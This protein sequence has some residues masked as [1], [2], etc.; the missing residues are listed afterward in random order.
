MSISVLLTGTDGQSD[1]LY[2]LESLGDDFFMRRL[3]AAVSLTDVKQLNTIRFTSLGG[4][5]CANDIPSMLRFWMKEG[6]GPTALGL[7]VAAGEL[8]LHDL[9]GLCLT[10]HLCLTKHLYSWTCRL[11]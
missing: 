11:V 10:M 5:L 8:Q 2:F 4:V 3:T 7:E 1:L 9:Q 6:V